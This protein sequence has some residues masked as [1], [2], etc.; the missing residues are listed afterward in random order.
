M[1]N[2]GLILLIFAGLLSLFMAGCTSDSRQADR[3]SPDGS[4]DALIG[5]ELRHPSSLAGTA[6]TDSE[7]DAVSAEPFPGNR[8]SGEDIPEDRETL[9]AEGYTPTA[10]IRQSTAA[11]PGFQLADQF[12]QL[13]DVT[14]ADLIS[15]GAELQP[16]GEITSAEFVEAPGRERT[17][18]MVWQENSFMVTVRN[19]SSESS[20]IKNS[21]ITALYTSAPVLMAPGGIKPGDAVDDLVLSLGEPWQIIKGAEFNRSYSHL[22]VYCYSSRWDDRSLS[23]FVDNGTDLIISFG[24]QLPVRYFSHIDQVSD[25]QVRDLIEAHEADPASRFLSAPYILDVDGSEYGNG[26]LQDLRYTEASLFTLD[27]IRDPD[28]F[29]QN[30]SDIGSCVPLSCLMI[31]YEAKLQY[32][33]EDMERFE[34]IGKRLDLS[35]PVFGCFYILNPVLDENGEIAS[36]LG[37]VRLRDLKGVYRDRDALLSELFTRKEQGYSLEDYSVSSRQ[38]PAA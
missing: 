13:G 26:V 8:E 5:E 24:E 28:T 31:E 9:P 34:F 7:E 2:R 25:D 27:E 30:I 15:D 1:K 22:N 38:I 19:R 21:D 35:Y 6:V 14:V 36:D 4:V 16:E 17:L 10:E 20:A 33:E 32:S 12:Y 18:T 37:L 3:A 11:D 29:N 23:F